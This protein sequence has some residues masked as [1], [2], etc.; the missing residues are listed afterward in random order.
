MIFFENQT[1]DEKILQIN[2][3]KNI[4]FILIKT[5]IHLQPIKKRKNLY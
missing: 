4:I 5:S 1:F 2:F 3:S